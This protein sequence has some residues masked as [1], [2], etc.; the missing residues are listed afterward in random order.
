MNPDAPGARE[1][2][3]AGDPA[4]SPP[5]RPAS[6]SETVRRGGFL[7]FRRGLSWAEAADRVGYPS[8]S[9]GLRKAWDR[10]PRSEQ[11]RALVEGLELGTKPPV[12]AESSAVGNPVAPKVEDAQAAPPTAVSGPPAELAELHCRLDLLEQERAS[13]DAAISG[14]KT[15]LGAFEAASDDRLAILLTDIRG[16]D[17]RVT[18]IQEEQSASCLASK[19]LERTVEEGFRSLLNLPDRVANLEAGATAWSDGARLAR[20][21]EEW[22]TQLRPWIEGI[23]REPLE[24]TK[25]LQRSRE[26]LERAT[27]RAEVQD[28]SIRQLMEYNAY[29]RQILTAAGIK[30]P[31]RVA[32][33]P[34]LWRRP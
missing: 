5:D 30:I 7:H 33:D 10:L 1:D 18:A 19:Q 11:A 26:A 22:A 15:H 9:Q 27:K 25:E 3:T 24:D 34:A 16:V 29:L 13:A 21:L 14:M 8:G 31:A 28:G 2:P 32:D 12:R 4:P 6:Q 20:R 17:S 23:L